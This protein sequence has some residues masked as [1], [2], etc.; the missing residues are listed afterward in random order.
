MTIVRQVY[1]LCCGLQVC[2]SYSIEKVLTDVEV[3][4]NLHSLSN[5]PAKGRVFFENKEFWLAPLE[6]P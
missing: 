4:G 3:E 5:G 2:D 6:I 1:L